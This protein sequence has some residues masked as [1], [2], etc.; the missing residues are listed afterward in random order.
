MMISIKEMYLGETAEIVSVDSSNICVKRLKDMGLREGKLIDML[1]Y[2]PLIN[3][4]IIINVDNSMIAFDA[5][6]AEGIKVRPLKS[7]YEV[8]KTQ[9]NHDNLTGCLNRHSIE[10]I[11][12]GE[13]QK[14]ISNEIPLSVLLADIDY[15]KRINDT[16]GH[17]AGDMVLKGISALF[18]QVLRRSDCLC[19]WGGEEFLILLRGTLVNEA[20]QI[21]ERLRR[22]VEF[23]IFQPFRGS[24]FVTISI[25]G[26]GMPPASDIEQTI[27][28]A[29]NALYDAKR[30]GRNRVNICEV[31][32]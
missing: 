31:Q 28:T 2:D 5:L 1:H 16:Y 30:N 15:F 8:V 13:S 4:K 22:S 20:V 14:F 23:C 10:C 3:N 29:D 9:A 24:G 17:S 21:A 26:C 19:R 12:M 18:K 32:Q 27:K 25:G 6:L 11:L 7:Y